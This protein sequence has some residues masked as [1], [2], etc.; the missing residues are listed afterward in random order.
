[1]RLQRKLSTSTTTGGRALALA[2]AG[3]FAAPQFALEAEVAAGRLIRLLPTLKLPQ[4]TLY[5]A[6]PGHSE[7]PSKTRAFI[8]LAKARLRP[9][10]RAPSG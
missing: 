10:T 5:A 3:V 8:E 2:G 1:M 4:V 7:P 9:V 6:W